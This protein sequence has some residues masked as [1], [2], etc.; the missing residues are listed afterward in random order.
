MEVVVPVVP[1]VEFVGDV[2]EPGLSFGIEGAVERVERILS[3]DDI[4]SGSRVPR[5]RGN[6]SGLHHLP[7][8]ERLC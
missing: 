1:V 4:Q 2:L 8:P 6:C 5:C 3:L 7:L